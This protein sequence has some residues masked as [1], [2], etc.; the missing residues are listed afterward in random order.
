MNLLSNFSNKE[1]EGYNNG[2]DVGDDKGDEDEELL[3]SD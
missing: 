3:D 1:G 2:T